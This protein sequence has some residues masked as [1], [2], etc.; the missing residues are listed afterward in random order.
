[1]PSLLLQCDRNRTTNKKGSKLAESLNNNQ[2][3]VFLMLHLLANKM[4]A[5]HVG[6]NSPINAWKDETTKMEKFGSQSKQSS[7]E[8]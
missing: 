3:D 2:L 6:L 5:Y 1:M 8:I 4:D 7:H